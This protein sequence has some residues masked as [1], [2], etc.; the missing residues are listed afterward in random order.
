[1][2]L[3]WR[4]L[5]VLVTRLPWESRVMALVRNL[6]ET[7]EPDVDDLPDWYR[8]LHPDVRPRRVMSDTEWINRHDRKG[9]L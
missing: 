8:A 3:P 6:V 7:A 1:M 9:A 2:G 5:R 4:R